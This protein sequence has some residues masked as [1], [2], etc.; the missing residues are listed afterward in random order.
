MSFGGVTESGS[1][2]VSAGGVVLESGSGNG[3]DG[4]LPGV[5]GLVKVLAVPEEGARR[6]D[7]HVS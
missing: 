5:V 4:G 6:S 3:I 7:S 1:R 2:K